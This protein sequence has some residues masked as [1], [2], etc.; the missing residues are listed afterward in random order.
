MNLKGALP[1][2]STHRILSALWPLVRVQA[3][4]MELK[5]GAIITFGLFACA[6]AGPLHA[7]CKVDW[8]FGIPCH[9]VYEALVSQIKK[10]SKADCV[11][12]GEKCMYKLESANA[13]FIKAKHTTPVKKYIEDLNFRLIPYLLDI[14]CHVPAFSVSEAWYTLVDYGTNYCNLYNLI[15]GSGLNTVPGY[16]EMTNDF[17]CTQHSSAN[18]TIF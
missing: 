14:G 4:D 7:Q 16:K 2:Q 1:P 8:Y 3:E 18:C 11:D 10:W 15:E 12:G 5:W 13:H 6:A 9:D 17:I